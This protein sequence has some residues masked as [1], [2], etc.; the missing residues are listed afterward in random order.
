MLEIEIKIL[1]INKKEMELK[2]ISLGAEKIID[3]I[4]E[5]YYLDKNS[6]LTKKKNVL[7]LRK[8]GDKNFITFKSKIEDKNYSKREEHEIEINNFEN[9]LKLL[10]GLGFEIIE[11]IKKHRTS[12]KINNTKFEIDEHLEDNSF[13]PCLM[14]I[15][16]NNEIEIEKYI[17]ILNINKNKVSKFGFFG[18]KKYYK[19]EKK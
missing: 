12:Y 5:T 9:A 18:L 11:K 10:N 6:E 7:R 2:L 3:D 19:S 15:E 17:N 4:V 14:E 13:I 8:I 16:S 1:E